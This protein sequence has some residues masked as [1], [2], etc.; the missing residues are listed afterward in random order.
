MSLWLHSGAGKA[1]EQAGRDAGGGGR[2][3][4]K[5]RMMK[6]NR[7]FCR[8][9]GRALSCWTG[10]TRLP[11][12][13]T[14]LSPKLHPR[15][16]TISSH[17]KH[18]HN[19]LQYCPSASREAEHSRANM[20]WGFH[21]GVY[22]APTALCTPLPS[23]IERRMVTSFKTA[24][25]SD[26]IAALAAPRLHTRT[27]TQ[28][29]THLW[30]DDSPLSHMAWPSATLPD[31]EDPGEDTDGERGGDRRPL[32]DVNHRWGAIADDGSSWDDASSSM[33]EKH[34]W[35]E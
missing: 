15:M 30:S 20:A 23:Q 26:I 13:F 35:G 29:H 19:S 31:R 33:G 22:N 34:R 4:G 25:Q 9:G 27:H 18:F 28:T 2:E 1:E 3:M 16:H 8:G 7:A 17:R 12:A 14:K 5:R 11:L 10:D 6:T 21:Q 32:G 24:N